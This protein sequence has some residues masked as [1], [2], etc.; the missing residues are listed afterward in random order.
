MKKPKAEQDQAELLRN[1]RESLGGITTEELSER[2]GK[3]LPTLRSWLLPAGNKARRNMP[4][5]SR[6]L[7]TRIV[8]E[9]RAKAKQ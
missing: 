2:L 6:M 1:A 7:L 4:R 8:A 9:H 5:G 3:S